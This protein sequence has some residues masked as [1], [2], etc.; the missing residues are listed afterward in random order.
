METLTLTTPINCTLEVLFDFHLD[1]N[2]I[3]QIT[4]SHTQVELI[5]Y[6]ERTYEGKIIKLKTTRAMIPINWVVTI[7][8]FDRPN[9]IVDRA[10]KSPFGFWKHHHIFTQ[11]GDMCELTDTIHYTPPFGLFGKI[12]APLIRKDIQNMFAYR[13]KQTKILLES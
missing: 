1:T 2:N 5:D 11:K 7:E 3:K 10:I 12:L 13:H 4:P 9:E 6:E 8:K